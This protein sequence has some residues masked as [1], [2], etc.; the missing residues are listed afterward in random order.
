VSEMDKVVQQTAANSEEAA[1][2]SEELSAQA[3]QMKHFVREL[4]SMI[5]GSRGNA[6]SGSNESMNTISV[7]RKAGGGPQ[8]A[9]A[10]EGKPDKGKG[11][12]GFRKTKTPAMRLIPFDDGEVNSF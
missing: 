5:D 10:F 7:E 2:A 6:V 3:E 4:K 8:R 1:A 9:F 11:H 12:G